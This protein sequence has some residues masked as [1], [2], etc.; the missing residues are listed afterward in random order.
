[1]TPKQALCNTLGL[2][3]KE[4]NEY[5]YQPTKVKGVYVIGETYYYAGKKP[6]IDLPWQEGQDQFWAE[7]ANTKIWISLNWI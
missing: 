3:N 4:L 7:K 2:T 6:P 5:A 1:M